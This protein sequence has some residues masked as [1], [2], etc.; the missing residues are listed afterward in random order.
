MKPVLKPKIGDIRQMVLP[1]GGDV[2]TR[3]WA[4]MRNNKYQIQKWIGTKAISSSAGTDAL[5]QLEKFAEAG[6]TIF[7]QAWQIT[8]E[9]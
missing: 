4:S 2:T 3:I 5:A 6:S 9:R 7:E 8:T 1:G